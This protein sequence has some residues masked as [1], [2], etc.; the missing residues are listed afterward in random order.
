MSL[1]AAVA[2]LQSQLRGALSDLAHYERKRMSHIDPTADPVASRRQTLLEE[3]DAWL[4]AVAHAGDDPDAKKTADAG[5][6]KLEKAIA[7]EYAADEKA[8]AKGE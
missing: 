1:A 6:A 5:L 7:A 3:R 2:E 4:R 8:A